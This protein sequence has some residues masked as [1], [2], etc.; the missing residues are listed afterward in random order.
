MDTRLG[1]F[2]ALGSVAGGSTG[3]GAQACEGESDGVEVA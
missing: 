2:A 1:C 3:R